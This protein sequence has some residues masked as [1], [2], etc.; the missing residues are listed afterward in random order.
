M[1]TEIGVMLAV[2]DAQAAVEFYKKAFRAEV[3][4]TV[5]DSGHMVAGSRLEERGFF[6][7]NERRSLGRGPSKWRRDYWTVRD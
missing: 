6:C 7:R 5:G 3:H 1:T 4:W 2:N